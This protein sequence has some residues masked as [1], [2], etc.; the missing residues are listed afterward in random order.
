MI[1]IPILFLFLFCIHSGSAQETGNPIKASAVQADKSDFPIEKA[2]SGLG[3]D[4]SWT[5]DLTPESGAVFKAGSD[6]YVAMSSMGKIVTTED[7][8]IRFTGKKDETEMIITLY[9]YG[10]VD[11]SSGEKFSHKVRVGIKKEG[12]SLYSIF[13]GCGKYQDK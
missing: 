3:H 9:G 1:K 6:L 7:E 2:F 8:V 5:L 10:C 13:E 12:D 4:P 11:K